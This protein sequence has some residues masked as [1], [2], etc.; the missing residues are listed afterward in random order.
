MKLTSAGLLN[1]LDQVCLDVSGNSITSINSITAKSL[2]TNSAGLI[3]KAANI[4]NKY[5]GLPYFYVP[6]ENDGLYLT[7]N[8]KL[9]YTIA[10]R[11]FLFYR[12]E[13]TFM[14][15]NSVDDHS[16]Y[17]ANPQTNRFVDLHP[18]YSNPPDGKFSVV[19]LFANA[20]SNVL[21]NLASSQTNQLH[22][23]PKHFDALHIGAMQSF[24]NLE[25]T[26]CIETTIWPRVC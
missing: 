4:N 17:L 14:C 25:A 22:S 15:S 23:V 21:F 16:F 26:Q 3:I 6:V 10:M 20:T 2:K 18:E 11:S 5:T 12:V 13:L 9:T 8:F 1:N 24:A 19:L 7:Q